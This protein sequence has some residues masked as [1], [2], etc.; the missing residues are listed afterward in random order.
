MKSAGIMGEGRATATF[1]PSSSA[2][3]QFSVTRAEPPLLFFS[4]RQGRQSN[5]VL[6]VE[7]ARF[8]AEKLGRQLVLPSCH[9][10]PLGEQACAYRPDIPAQRQSVVSMNLQKLLHP[11]DLARCRRPPGIGPSLMTLSEL[12]LTSVPR[13]VT[14]LEICLLYTSPS[15]RD[16]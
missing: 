5:C 12:P 16:S 4:T 8:L 7:V 11:R 14:C 9:T 3:A 10:S 2:L 15:P 6:T 1:T 13:N